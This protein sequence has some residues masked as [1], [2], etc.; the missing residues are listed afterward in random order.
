LILSGDRNIVSGHH[1][2]I[3][4]SFMR[5][6]NILAVASVAVALSAVSAQAGGGMPGGG[7]GSGLGHIIYST[8]GDAGAVV[9]FSTCGCRGAEFSDHKKSNS[10]STITQTRNGLTLGTTSTSSVRFNAEHVS[11][12]GSNSVGASSYIS[13]LPPLG[14]VLY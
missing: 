5:I 4:E 8:G 12:W 10:T 6:V 2:F 13:N 1:K 14:P 3:A 9:N 11:V 7:M